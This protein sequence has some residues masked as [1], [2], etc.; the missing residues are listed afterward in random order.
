MK[1]VFCNYK[2]GP[3]CSSFIR[4]ETKFPKLLN[5]K[6]LYA[7]ILKIIFSKICRR[8]T[9]TTK[10]LKLE[11]RLLLNDSTNLNLKS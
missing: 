10:T 6:F 9:I 8:L 1:Y 4:K 5:L 2:Q 11:K 3:M 7:F